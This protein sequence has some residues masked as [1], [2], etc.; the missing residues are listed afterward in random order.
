MSANVLNAN[1]PYLNKL[2]GHESVLPISPCARDI[3]KCDI[4]SCVMVT[5]SCRK[6]AWLAFR[7]VKVYLQWHP[8]NHQIQLTDIDRFGISNVCQYP[9]KT[10]Y[11]V[12]I[13]GSG[14]CDPCSIIYHLFCLIVVAKHEMIIVLLSFSLIY[15]KHWEHPSLHIVLCCI[16]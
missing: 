15:V 2:K 9:V 14:V 16:S 8:Q 5:L 11:V 3:S 6:N 7:V 4:L 1:K 13:L 12:R 10:G